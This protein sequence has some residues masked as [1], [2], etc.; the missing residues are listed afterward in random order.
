M[1]EVAAKGYTATGAQSIAAN[2][3]ET[4]LVVT[5]PS[6]R[7]EVIDRF[8]FGQ[9]G[10]NNSETV[11]VEF[12]RATAAGS[13]GSAVT[14]QP[15]QVNQGATGATVS[16]SPTTEPTYPAEEPYRKFVVNVALGRDVPVF[17]PIVVP[18]SGIVGMRVTNRTGNTAI[19]SPRAELHFNEVG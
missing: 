8:S 12:L 4:M 10:H 11:L 1:V 6:T 2:A 15:D 14:P 18:P 9:D 16:R 17:P 3:T 7:V 5:A 19:S 13:G